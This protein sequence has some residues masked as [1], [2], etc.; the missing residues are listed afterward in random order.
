MQG[1]AISASLLPPIVNC[2]IGCSFAIIGPALYDCVGAAK[3]GTR[4]TVTTEMIGGQL[5]PV[6][7]EKSVE[8]S[9]SVLDYGA[10]SLEVRICKTLKH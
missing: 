7:I 2:G 8:V 9:H 3:F 1:V 4:T 6:E 5:W 10:W